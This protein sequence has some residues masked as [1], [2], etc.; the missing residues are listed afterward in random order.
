MHIIQYLLNLNLKCFAYDGSGKI[1]IAGYAKTTATIFELKSVLK[2]VPFDIGYDLNG[3]EWR[4]IDVY[5][6]NNIAYYTAYNGTKTVVFDNFSL[7]NAAEINYVYQNK[8]DEKIQVVVDKLKQL[9]SYIPT[10]EKP[11]I[12]TT[13]KFLPDDIAYD[14]NGIEWR[15]LSVYESNNSFIIEAT[16]ETEIKTFKEEELFT[17]AQ[18]TENIS[19]E[20]NKLYN[21]A[22]INAI[23]INKLD[24]RIQNIANMLRQLE[25]YVPTPD[26]PTAYTTIKFRPD[27][28]A[29]DID[30]IEWR[31]ISIH[32]SNNSFIIK[33]TNQKEIK[34]FEE[35]DLFVNND[36]DNLL[37]K[38]KLYNAAQIEKIYQTNLDS[39]IQLVIDKINQL[40]GIVF[41]KNK[42]NKGEF[43]I[44]KKLN[45]WKIVSVLNL[46]DKI[47]YQATNGKVTKIFNENDLKKTSKK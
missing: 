34:N 27:D 30:G 22:Q 12:Y 37:Q 41:S 6:N 15:I 39:K 1:R 40:G 2:F 38:N 9:E 11:P 26:K 7:F 5:Y 10:P 29:Y 16:N 42:F 8:L 44:D 47:K 35:N 4:I 23:Y 32:E 19:L 43:C 17:T 20:E 45:S 3:V 31:I 13:I 18:L 25:S 24:D 33:A 28:I 36:Q 14:I 46:K 21:A